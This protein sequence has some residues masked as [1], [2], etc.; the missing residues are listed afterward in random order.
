MKNKRGHKKKY[1]KEAKSEKQN[2]T[3]AKFRKVVVRLL[4]RENTCCHEERSN[5]HMI[6]RNKKK[7]KLLNIFV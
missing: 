4:D 3:K 6:L 2:E 5:T 7:V 1:I